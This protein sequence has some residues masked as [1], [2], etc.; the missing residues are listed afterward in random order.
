MSGAERQCGIDSIAT[1]ISLKSWSDSTWRFNHGQ[2]VIKYVGRGQ[3]LVSFLIGEMIN[4]LSSKFF[5]CSR[6]S[7]TVRLINNT[8]P[9]LRNI[10]GEM[11]NDLSPKFSAHVEIGQ[12][13]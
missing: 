11:M 10:C 3:L 12:T 2:K 7:D 13:F 5:I 1:T 9:A 8:V 6:L 4:D